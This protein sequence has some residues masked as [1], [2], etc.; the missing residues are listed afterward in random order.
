MIDQYR[1]N[2]ATG[3]LL[4]NRAFLDMCHVFLAGETH[5]VE[6]G[7]VTIDGFY[8]KSISAALDQTGWTIGNLLTDSVA[9]TVVHNYQKR[10]GESKIDGPLMSFL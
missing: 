9:A 5:S 1:I 4:Q 6:D 2:T 10:T 8:R 7:P 3:I